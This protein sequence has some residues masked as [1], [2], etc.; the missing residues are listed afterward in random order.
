MKSSVDEVREKGI[1]FLQG[2]FDNVR[3]SAMNYSE[4]CIKRTLSGKLWC[5]LNTGCPP[6]TGFDIYMYITPYEVSNAIQMNSG[7]VYNTRR[8]YDDR[9]LH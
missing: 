6:N 8:D 4:T 5:P 9:R 7:S 1:A 2:N 3:F